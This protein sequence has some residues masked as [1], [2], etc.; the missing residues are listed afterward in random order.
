MRLPQLRVLAGT[1]LSLAMVTGVSAVASNAATA[2][3]THANHATTSA[4][5]TPRGRITAPV[6][7]T[8]TNKAGQGHFTGSFKPKKFTVNHGV[9]QA[10][11]VLTGRL[12][13]AKGNKLG[14]V[15]R[16][17]TFPV[18]TSRADALPACSILNLVLGPLH[19]NLLGLQVNLNRVH[20]TIRA[21][22]GAGNLL[23]NL[24]CQ[25]T[26]LLDSGGSLSQISALLNRVLSLL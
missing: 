10:T 15:D 26:H 3:T 7:G 11:G 21:L 20:L 9:L 23:G 2:S 4:T 16:T 25:I 12:V 24:L 5:A 13:S 14:T 22:P 19:L 1:A 18:G 17:V 6:T 8:F